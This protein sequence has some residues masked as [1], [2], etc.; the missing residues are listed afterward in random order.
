MLGNR[1]RVVS[2]ECPWG[3]GKRLPEIIFFAL[4]FFTGGCLASGDDSTSTPFEPPPPVNRPPVA[5]G[6]IPG[7]RM[8]E[9]ETVSVNVSSNFSD[10]DGDALTYSASSSNPGVVRAS[11]SG[12]VLTLNGA[13]EGSATVS[14]TARD[15]GGLA[16]TLSTT[17]TVEPG[18]RPPETVETL[19]AQQMY[20]WTIRSIDLSPYFVDPDGDDLTY[21]GETSDSDV[22]VVEMENQT[23]LWLHLKNVGL[24]TVSVVAT[25]PG[26][27]SVS[28]SFQVD[29]LPNFRD[30][31]LSSVP[32]RTESWSPVE[33]VKPTLSDNMLQLQLDGG[34]QG[35]V[36]HPAPHR[37][38]D[39]SSWEI[40]SRMARAETTANAGIFF[41]TEDTI[42]TRFWFLFGSGPR[43]VKDSVS[44]PVN[45][46]LVYQR[47]DSTALWTRDGYWGTSPAIRDGPDEFT[48][49]SIKMEGGTIAIRAGGIELVSQRLPEGFVTDLSEF[50]L[51]MVGGD[52][53][54]TLFD[55]IRVSRL[56]VQGDY[57]G[58]AKSIGDEYEWSSTWQRQTIEI[59]RTP[60]RRQTRGLFGTASKPLPMV[61]R[62]GPADRRWLVAKELSQSL[63]NQNNKENISK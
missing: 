45:Y 6:Q 8:I 3:L 49:V 41:T 2:G 39:Y 30:D 63:P 48:E 14:V 53:N 34:T 36:R 61:Q 18:N 46:I 28:R 1:T 52:G 31:F 56:G 10:P 25:D 20:E 22:V 54:R 57:V 38:L 4:V 60:A 58:L 33:S 27:L 9:G 12:S 5:T 13:S 51:G 50:A 37:V 40:R 42:W 55:W 32:W 21:S 16:A 35:D 59:P 26:G 23:D 15:P 7:Q 47:R 43:V 44:I 62:L 19:Q 29:V 24:S 11:M 17:A